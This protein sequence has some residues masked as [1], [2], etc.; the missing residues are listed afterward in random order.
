M[1]RQRRPCRSFSKEF[2]AEVVELVRQPGNTAGSGARRCRSA[3]WRPSG[4]D[5]GHNRLVVLVE[6]DAVH[7]RALDAEQALP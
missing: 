5:R 6:H 2:K 4:P 7:H 1:G 3:G